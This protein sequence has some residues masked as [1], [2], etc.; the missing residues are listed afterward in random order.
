MDL[1]ISRWS[2]AQSRALAGLLAATA[3]QRVP[4]RGRKCQLRRA[5][6]GTKEEQKQVQHGPLG[7]PR[8]AQ[9]VTQV[10]PPLQS[11]AIGNA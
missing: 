8:E 11:L 3:A 6:D 10:N 7:G 1:S 4:Q 9:Q 5:T 2:S